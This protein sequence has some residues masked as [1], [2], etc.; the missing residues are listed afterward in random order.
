[1]PNVQ[2]FN[3]IFHFSL[4]IWTCLSVHDIKSDHL[5][6]SGAIAKHNVYSMLWCIMVFHSILYKWTWRIDRIL[7]PHPESPITD[8]PQTSS[9]FSLKEFSKWF[10]M[11]LSKRLQTHDKGLLLLHLHKSFMVLKRHNVNKWLNILEQFHV[12]KPK[13]KQLV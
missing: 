2:I 9:C 12:F 1:M 11:S 10:Y 8:Q 4:F 7:S 3:S 13:Y 5:I 6:I